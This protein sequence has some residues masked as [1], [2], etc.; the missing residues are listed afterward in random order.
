MELYYGIWGDTRSA[1][2]D[3]ICIFTEVYRWRTHCRGCEGIAAGK[4]KK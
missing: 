3:Y 1:G 2:S 4:L